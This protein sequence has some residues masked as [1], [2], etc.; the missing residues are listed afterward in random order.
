M[1]QTLPTRKSVKIRQ[2]IAAGLLVLTDIYWLIRVIFPFPQQ[3]DI[4]CNLIVQAIFLSAWGLLCTV[5]SNK[6]SRISSIIIIVFAF[7]YALLSFLGANI[8]AGNPSEYIDILGYIY[9]YQIFKPLT[10]IYAYSILLKG[11]NNLTATDKTWAS[12]IILTSIGVFAMGLY[13]AGLGFMFP[14]RDYYFIR[15]YN[16]ST[17]LGWNFWN[18]AYCILM[19]VAEFRVAKC[20]AFAG[21]YNPEPAPKGTYSP[22][23][24]YFA[25]VIVTVPIVLGLLWV[26]Y[27]NLELIESIF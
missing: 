18:I 16:F 7:V 13:F 19:A 10:T 27:S 23:N 6:A 11:N 15:Q 3:A 14:Q 4:L 24:K 1:E 5:A 20:V 2:N 22:I 26:V 9:I 12:Y 21:N 25:A 17:S 8:E